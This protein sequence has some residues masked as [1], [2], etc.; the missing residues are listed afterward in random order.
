[1]RTTD[2][3]ARR[4]ARA[5]AVAVLYEADQH[6]RAG[7]PVALLDLLGRR[8]T[9]TTAQTALPQ[10]AADIIEGVA[11]HHTHLDE[12]L[13]TFAHGWTLER[14]P[15]VDRAILRMG[16]WELLYN[17]DVPTGVA[18]DEAVSLAKELSTDDS[19]DFVNGLLSR[20]GQL[21]PSLLE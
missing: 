9:L 21:G 2:V 6:M 8:L 18:I 19:P 11:T 17:D 10:Y 16:A 12:V 15:A 1:M 14:M 20:I 4:K 3:S 5:R 7:H 13:G